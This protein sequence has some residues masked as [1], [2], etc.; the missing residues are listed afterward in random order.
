MLCITDCNAL[1]SDCENLH[2]DCKAPHCHCEIRQ[3]GC[4]GSDQAKGLPD[5]ACRS[6]D[7]L[8]GL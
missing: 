6:T 7:G 1:H 5:R 3:P 4:D 2:S 8:H